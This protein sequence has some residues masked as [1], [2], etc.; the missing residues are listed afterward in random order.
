M[1]PPLVC[2]FCLG[3]MLPKWVTGRL[4]VTYVCEECFKDTYGVKYEAGDLR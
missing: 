2:S 4:S 3:Q 1:E